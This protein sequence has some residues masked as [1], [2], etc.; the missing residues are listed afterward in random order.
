MEGWIS[1]HRKFLEWEWFSVD[2]M[3][4]LFLFL[5]LSANHKN[6][7][8][9]G[10]NV[11]RGQLITSIKT[12]HQKTKISQ[13]SIRTCLRRLEKTGEI[14]RQSTNKYSII[15]VCKYEEYQSTQTTTNKQPNKQSTSNQQ[16][17]NQIRMFPLVIQLDNMI[18]Y[19]LMLFVVKHFRADIN[20]IQ[21]VRVDKYRTY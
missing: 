20:I 15:T 3:V 7:K 9:R 8:W 12:L 5:L 17:T 21:P 1:L 13:Q 16:T 18:K 14:N 11:E 10:I 4:K 6:G 2:E 19:C